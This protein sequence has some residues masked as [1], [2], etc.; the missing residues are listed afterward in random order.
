MR[1]KDSQE[2]LFYPV[3]GIAVVLLG[4]VSYF[5][6]QRLINLQFFSPSP[7]PVEPQ[8]KFEPAMGKAPLSV[9]RIIPAQTE[10]TPVRIQVPA[11]SRAKT[12]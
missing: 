3:V 11:R 2:H 1:R 12:R 6:F 4:I 8:P 10:Q 9:P 7:S 5:L